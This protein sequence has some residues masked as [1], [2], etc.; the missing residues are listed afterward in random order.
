[1]YIM[2]IGIRESNAKYETGMNELK[3]FYYTSFDLKEKK[4]IISNLFFYKCFGFE[5][6]FL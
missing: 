4:C 3:L 5:T 2:Y 6:S 1:M